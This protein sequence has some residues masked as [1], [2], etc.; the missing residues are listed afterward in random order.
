MPRSSR[1]GAPT[2]RPSTTPPRTSPPTPPAGPAPHETRRNHVGDHRAVAPGSRRQ[3]PRRTSPITASVQQVL[4]STSV[5]AVARNGRLDLLAANDL[6]R[7]LYADL[8]TMGRQPRLCTARRP[9]RLHHPLH[10]RS[11]YA[12]R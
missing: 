12:Q 10:R 3:R 7:A 4:D 6:G 1:P 2:C 9:A 5:P 11:R 8:F